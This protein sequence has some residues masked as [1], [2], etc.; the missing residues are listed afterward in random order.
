MEQHSL[1]VHITGEAPPARGEGKL[2]SLA[3]FIGDVRLAIG[4][5]VL[6]RR[7]LLGVWLKVH[8]TGGDF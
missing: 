8:S 6:E 2:P 5:G 7:K 4:S 1:V 3:A